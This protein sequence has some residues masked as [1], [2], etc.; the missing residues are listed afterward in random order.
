M[1]LTLNF[2]ETRKQLSGSNTYL[3]HSLVP[4]NL[5]DKHIFRPHNGHFHCSLVLHIHFLVSHTHDLSILGCNGNDLSYSCHF[6]STKLGMFLKA[7]PIK[8]LVMDCVIMNIRSVRKETAQVFKSH[9]TTLLT[10]KIPCLME[11]SDYDVL[12]KIL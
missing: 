9:V 11:Q 3:L 8:L 7:K 5:G 6:P 2:M 10:H 4:E 12:A 1:N